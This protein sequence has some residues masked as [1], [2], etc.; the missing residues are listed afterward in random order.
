MKKGYGE[1]QGEIY[2]GDYKT[3]YWKAVKNTEEEV[4]SLVEIM[5]NP[6]SFSAE[7]YKLTCEEDGPKWTC[8]HKVIA[9]DFLGGSVYGYGET[10]QEALIDSGKVLSQFR[11]SKERQTDGKTS[12]GKG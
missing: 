9:Y 12:G 11:K 5:D 10:P 3:Q 7:E 1:L 2:V 8:E 6:W 4:E